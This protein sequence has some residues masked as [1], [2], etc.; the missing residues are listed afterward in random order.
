MTNILFKEDNNLIIYSDHILKITSGK[1]IQNIQSM[2]INQISL[3]SRKILISQETLFIAIKGDNHDGHQFIY[4]LYQKGI[5][6][7]II[8]DQNIDLQQL[9]EAN[10]ILV[11]NS[12]IALQNIANYHRN[13]FNIPIIGITGSNGKTIIKEWLSQSLSLKY[14][15]VK[16]PKSHN[17]QIG[18]P[19]SI[20]KINDSHQYGIFEAGI[21]SP[22]EMINLSNIINP[23]IGIF[24]NLGSAHEEG[25]K[26]DYHKAKEKTILFKNCDKIYYNDD[27]KIIDEALQELIKQH[28]NRL[29]S[30]SRNNK[31][32]QYYVEYIS[33]NSTKTIIEINS[34]HKFEVSFKDKI[35]LENATHCIIFLLNEFEDI[36]LIKKSIKF[37]KSIPMRLTLKK[38]VNECQI[39]DDSYSNDIISLNAALEFMEDQNSTNLKKTIILSDFM[40]ISE[41]KEQFYLKIANLLKTKEINRILGIGQDLTQ[42]KSSFNKFK[43]TFY[44]TTESFLLDDNLAF[45]NELILIKGARKFNFENIV[46]KLQEKNHET[47]LE[48]DLNA[49]TH[50]L[51]FFRSKLKNDT[52]L[53]VMVKAFSYGSS[54]FEIPNLLQYHRIDYLGVAYADEGIRLRKNGIT[55]PILVM[56]PTI[57]SFDDLI[58][59]NLE[60][61]LYSFNLL[62]AFIAKTKNNL[63]LIYPSIHIKVDTGMHRLGFLQND[64][65]DLLNILKNSKLK[66]KSIL[67]HLA[68]SESHEDDKYTNKQASLFLKIANQIE[69]ALKYKTIKHLLNSSGI[70]RFPQFQYGMVR[71]GIGL[72]GVGVNKEYLNSLEPSNCLST[73]ISQIKYL[74]KSSSIGYNRKEILKRDSK[75]AVIAIGY[76]DGFGRIM[77]NRKANVLINNTLAP[78]IGNICMDMCMI[79]I[80]DIENVNERDRVIIF[81]KDK[82][83]DELAN[84][85]GT[86]SYEILSQVNERVKRVYIQS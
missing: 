62:K 34:K 66:V 84:K 48:V 11:D 77:G 59:F 63:K 4:D 38:G 71:L 60:P 6:Q 37:F 53:L 81:G 80:T 43:T 18:V 20:L 47:I 69:Q 54:S 7:F 5:R 52:K 86:I 10:I 73:S 85:V 12:I 27:N 16:S 56:N 15:I 1:Y 67:S 36:D 2:L 17:S 9:P 32:S 51:N 22:S 33:E 76:A 78:I 42:F 19:L 21:S 61:V 58:K 82:S 79:D 30:W 35:N 46:N 26:S 44:P 25:F 3:D 41:S 14:K 39:I 65:D 72:H 31:N 49:I 50:N 55:L 75:I 24:T 83:I 29:I 28:N 23:T 64:I 8:E 68:S 57:E 74:P 13:K 45:K 70:L 40:Q